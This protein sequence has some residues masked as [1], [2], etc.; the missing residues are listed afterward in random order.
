M[1]VVPY[2]LLAFGALF[3]ILSPLGTVPTF[4]AL[5]EDDDSESR[6]SMARR[7]CFVAFLVMATFS[8]LG[9]RI[10]G[11]FHVGIPALQ[12]AGGIVILRVGLEMLG[13][14]RRRLTP[15][16]RK[17]ALE[18]DDVAITPL[19]VPM[20]CGPG[21]ITTGIVLESQAS[22]PFEVGILVA[23]TAAIYVMTFALLWLAVR[24]SAFFGQ[25]TRRVVGRLMGLLLAAVAVQFIL[26]GLAAAWPTLAG[27]R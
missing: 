6:L 17:E 25:I 12:I 22:N 24:Y 4:L 11:A 2:S 1:G 19:G 16:E 5:T 21:T 8:V 26:N 23:I 9:A 14:T 18:K 7:A 10:L 3:A 13:G 20:L 15:E 27:A